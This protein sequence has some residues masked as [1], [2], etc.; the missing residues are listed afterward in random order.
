MKTGTWSVGNEPGFT[1]AELLL[2]LLIISLLMAMV[3]PPLQLDV[4]DNAKLRRSQQEI[5]AGLRISRSKAINTREEVMLAIN[6]ADG[7]MRITGEQRKLHIPDD[8]TLT[9]NTAPF[10]EL[11]ENEGAIRFYPDGSSTGME[12]VFEQDQRVSR[13]SVDELTGRVSSF[14]E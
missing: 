11:P 13:I 14:D 7:R 9:M 6:P 5:V 1:L 2:V 4:V 3:V 12:L 8:V 10:E